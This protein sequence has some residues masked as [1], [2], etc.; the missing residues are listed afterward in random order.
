[1]LEMLG[2]LTFG[3]IV[4]SCGAGAGWLLQRLCRRAAAVPEEQ[5]MAKEVLAR[6]KDLASH[7]ATNVGQHSSRVEQI[8]QELTANR[9]PE[10]EGVISAVEQLIA[11]NQSMQSQLST[12]EVKLNEQ[13]RLVDLKAAEA[14]T[15]VLDRPGE[16]PG[17]RRQ[18][19]GILRRIPAEPPAILADPWRHRPLQEIQRRLRPPD[20]RRSAPQH[21]RVLRESARESDF[22]A[23]YGGEEMT[24]VLPGTEADEAIRAL[25]RAR[26]AVESARFRASPGELQ[27]TMSFGAAALL[28]GE[29]VAALIRRADAALYAAKEAGR[30]RGCWHDGRGIRPIGRPCDIKPAASP[31]IPETA[32]TP[33]VEPQA[34]SGLYSKHDFCASLGRRLAEW[35]RRGWPRPYC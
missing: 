24:I 4:I 21:A 34:V 26:Q 11:A 20:R 25:E 8:N 5:R 31:P 29:E 1:M 10:P 12:V 28:P 32:P 18:G 9:V 2:D 6:L 30:N 17:L 15:D 7:M 19:G 14:R 13:A 16:P 27:V 35:R 33:T 3:I 22:V 23:R